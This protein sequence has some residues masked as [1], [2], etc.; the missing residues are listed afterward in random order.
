MLTERL[1]QRPRGDRLTDRASR[2]II[3]CERRSTAS[4]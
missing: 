3:Q 4:E 1:A 2:P